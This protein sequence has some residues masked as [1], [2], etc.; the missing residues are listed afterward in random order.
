MS[1]RGGEKER[2]GA[3]KKKLMAGDEGAAGNH[4]LVRFWAV[5]G[6]K[7]F[8]IRNHTRTLE[9]RTNGQLSIHPKLQ[10][11]AEMFLWQPSEKCHMFSSPFFS[12]SLFADGRFVLT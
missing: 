2:S 7:L 10:L 11:T 12:L 1:S 5:Q 6:E 8:V 9:E 4:W 3:G